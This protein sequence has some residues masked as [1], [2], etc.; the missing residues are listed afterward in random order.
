ML[1]FVLGAAVLRAGLT[2]LY[3]RYLR[4][5]FRPVLVT[6]GVA[7]IVIAI[8]TG[9][10]EQ[11]AARAGRGREH[12]EHDRQEHD[13]QEH[14]RQEHDRQEHGHREPRIA[15]LLVLP[16]LALIV[17]VP[18]ALGSYAANRAGTGLL[19]PPGFPTL[20]GGDPLSTTVDDYATRAVYDHGS[21]AGRHI[22][23]TGF[24]AL[25]VGGTPY[26]IRMRVSCCAADAI[27]IKVALTGRVPP[28]LRQDSWVRVVGTYSSRQVKDVV[29]GRPIPFLDVDH[30][31]PVPAP[32]DPYET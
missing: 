4:A 31:Q 30:A 7:L 11:R 27:P 10:Y 6:A 2:D 12:Q 19:P 1:L 18:P 23:L 22:E 29:N 32:A 13:R 15:W 24:V 14:D 26:L 20:P 9:W 17:I 3:L 16:L 21:L 28:D 5:G 25:G 8:A